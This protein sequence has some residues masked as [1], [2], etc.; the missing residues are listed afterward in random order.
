VTRFDRR[1]IA[2]VGI[3]RR[4]KGMAT[5]RENLEERIASNIESTL[6]RLLAPIAQVE[7]L[8]RGEYRTSEEG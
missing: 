7:R 3:W 8:K 6:E 1:G 4:R 2:P 5:D